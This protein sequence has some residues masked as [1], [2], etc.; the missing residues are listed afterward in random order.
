[1]AAFELEDSPVMD[2]LI[3]ADLT[4]GPRGQR[5]SFG[6]RLGEILERYGPGSLVNRAMTAASPAL[7]DAVDRT[8]KRLADV[9]L[10]SVL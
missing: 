7:G 2:A 8:A 9:D 10:A 6:D 1:L 5:L 4:T 3:T